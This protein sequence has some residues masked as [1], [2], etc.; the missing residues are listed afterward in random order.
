MEFVKAVGGEE[1]HLNPFFNLESS[2]MEGSDKP[3]QVQHRWDS[4][5]NSSVLGTLGSGEK[6]FKDHR[7]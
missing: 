4:D 6:I 7:A 3:T 1:I 5:R 2:I